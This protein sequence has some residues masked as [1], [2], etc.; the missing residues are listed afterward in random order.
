MKAT[1]SLDAERFER[2]LQQLIAREIVGHEVAHRAA[3][4]RRVFEVPHV[5]VEPPAIQQKAAVSRR[6]LVVAIVQVDHARLRFFE[7]V[8]LHPRRPRIR[9][10]Q[11]IAADEAAVF[12]FDADD[13]VHESGSDE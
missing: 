9:P 7:E 12:G 6:L 13:A 5:D 4:R 10:V 1:S 8:I 11:R 2:R 3:L